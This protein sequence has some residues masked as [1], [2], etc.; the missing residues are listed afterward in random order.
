MLRQKDG[1]LEF[2]DPSTANP[3]NPDS[4]YAKEFDIPDDVLVVEHCYFCGK[5]LGIRFY[6]SPNSVWVDKLIEG[7]E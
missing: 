4:E 2:C 3:L 7:G 1:E 6:Y 5:D